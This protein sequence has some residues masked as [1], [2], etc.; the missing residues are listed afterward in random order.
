MLT[1]FR[2]FLLVIMWVLGL[3]LKIDFHVHTLYSDGTG[4]VKDVLRAAEHK[5]LD[6]LAITDHDTLEGYFEAKS[7]N[8]HLVV[9]PGYEVVTDAGHILVIGLER[10]PPN[11][12]GKKP[13]S[14]ES[15]IEWVRFNGGLSIL[16][17]PAIGK[18]KMDRWMR[19]KPDAIEVLNASYPFYCLYV[20]R[21]LK[22][23]SRLGVA[24]VG[25]SD[26]HS[27]LSIGDAYT[28]V[29]VAKKGS[30]I[31][32]IKRGRV[33]YGGGLSSPKM[34]LKTGAAYLF[35]RT[36]SWLLLKS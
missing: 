8:S 20:G 31:E 14:Y 26:A 12:G 9:L 29:E 25:G 11:I 28:V 1:S 32:A 35:S 4:S 27:P 21:G 15:L 30:I 17:H 3:H 6:G 18:L 2:P 22:V 10:L 19:H 33:K 24:G 23:S 34:R 13:S 16:A 5:G 36:Y 7:C